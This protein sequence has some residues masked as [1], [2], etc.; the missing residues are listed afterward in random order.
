M[1]IR[2]KFICLTIISILLV[3]CTNVDKQLLKASQLIDSGS[4]EKGI[5]I[6][7]TKNLNS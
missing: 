4:Y 2:Y 7:Q 6:D 1:E 3:G 5:K